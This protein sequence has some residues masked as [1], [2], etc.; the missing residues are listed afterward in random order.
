MIDSGLGYNKNFI[1]KML[2]ENLH[3]KFF[4]LDD[5]EVKDDKPNIWKGW[6]ETYTGVVDHLNK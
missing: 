5:L 2:A 6:S 1:P 4:L 3:G